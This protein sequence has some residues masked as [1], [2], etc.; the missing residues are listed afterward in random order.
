MQD[1]NIFYE[2]FGNEYLKILRILNYFHDCS[3]CDF[4]KTMKFLLF[5]TAIIRFEYVK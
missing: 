2:H 5:N 1:R 4:N 3:Y